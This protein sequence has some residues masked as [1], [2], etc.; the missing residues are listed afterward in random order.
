MLSIVVESAMGGHRQA[1][2]QG[3]AFRACAPSVERIGD[4]SVT[5]HGTTMVQPRGRDL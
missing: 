5:R 2:P 1:L 3:L 4:D